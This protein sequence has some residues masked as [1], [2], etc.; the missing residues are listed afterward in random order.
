MEQKNLKQ[1]I[2]CALKRTTPF[3]IFLAVLNLVRLYNDTPNFFI[4]LGLDLT[5]VGFAILGYTAGYI[6]RQIAEEKANVT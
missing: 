6:D 2:G 5:Q 4:H 1:V 3:L